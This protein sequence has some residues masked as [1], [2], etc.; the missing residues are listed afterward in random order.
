MP[1]IVATWKAEIGRITVKAS[2]GI[3]VLEN[4]FPK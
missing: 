3:I 4:P 2:P 1:I